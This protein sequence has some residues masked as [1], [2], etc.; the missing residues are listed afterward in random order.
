MH[1]NKER[2]TIIIIIIIKHSTNYTVH[3][4]LPILT[5]K[6]TSVDSQ[7]ADFPP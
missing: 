7:D 6:G 2:K 5:G 4:L 3:D 1:L